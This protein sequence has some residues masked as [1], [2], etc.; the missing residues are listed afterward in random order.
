MM[1]KRI[2]LAFF[3]ACVVGSCSPTM[4]SPTQSPT[5]TVP[6]TITS[7]PEPSA[8]PPITAYPWLQS[9]GPYL[10]FTRDNK[11]LMIMDADGRGQK[12]IKLPN[13]GYIFQLNKSVSP[14]GKWLAYLTGSTEA[15][16]D[17]ALN[18]LHLSNETTQSVSKLLATGFP[19]NVEPIIETMVLGDP[20]HYDQNCFENRECRKAL[21]QRELTNSLFNFD[22]SSDSQSIAFTAQIDGPSSDIYLYGI[23][24]KTIRQLTNELQ[25]IYWL[26][27]A[28]SGTKIL[29]EVSSTPGLA[30]EG[31][32]LHITDLEGKN[33]FVNEKYLYNKRWGES[34][35]L[36]E[37]LYLLDH[38]NDTD[39]PPIYDLM[40]VDTDTGQ[41]KAVWPYGVETFAMNR[42]DKTI[43]L[44]HKNH[45]TQKATVP[46]GIY[47]VYPS[48]KYWK[49]SDVGIQFVVR[50]GQK[51]Y[52]IFAQDYNGQIYS[53][54]HNGSIDMLPWATDKIPWISPDGSLLLFTEPQKLALYS[55]S[56]EPIRSWQ[57]ED[58]QYSL[59][60]SP[61]SLGVF[62]F[63]SL[64]TYYLP[65]REEQPRPLL[66]N[67]PLAH[68]EPA[69]F[70][71]LP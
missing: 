54:D 62:I 3:A 13:D 41:F 45:S 42:D 36:T 1:T 28:P 32:T 23:Q 17:V 25:N 18:L 56:Y 63:T 49:V 55:N 10:L 57:M 30:Y 26:D 5:A 33:T 21:V 43:V 38:P 2:I 59:T 52:P 35:W 37:N 15:P 12:Q 44:I 67:C 27:W 64:N 60:W 29:Y 47:I 20:P 70:V 16:Y 19:A 46:E 4:V 22:W 53:I 8:T 6:P 11:N 39:K 9:Q 68:C 31:R 34:D 50:E 66:E 7:S 69:R 65:I 71:W 14:D 24:E 58:D 51:P 48:G 40:I 61:D